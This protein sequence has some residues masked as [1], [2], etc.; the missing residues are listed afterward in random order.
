MAVFTE[1]Q[2]DHGAIASQ[3]CGKAAAAAKQTKA[4]AHSRPV[5]QGYGKAAGQG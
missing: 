5:C 3:D 1:R 4:S 2:L